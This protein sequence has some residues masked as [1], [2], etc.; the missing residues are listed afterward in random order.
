MAGFFYVLLKEKEKGWRNRKIEK[1]HFSQC[2]IFCAFIFL[3]GF[4][5]SKGSVINYLIKKVFVHGHVILWF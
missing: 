3:K 2:T 1:M 5:V 4:T